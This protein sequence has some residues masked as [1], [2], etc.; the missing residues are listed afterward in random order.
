M[1]ITLASKMMVVTQRKLNDKH[2][3]EQTKPMYGYNEDPVG[4]NR[5]AHCDRDANNCEY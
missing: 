3:S 4:N 1:S 2:E 5:D